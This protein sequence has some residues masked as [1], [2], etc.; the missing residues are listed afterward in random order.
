MNSIKIICSLIFLIFFA[1]SCTQQSKSA[2]LTT[3]I[4]C[5]HCNEC[6]SCK[7]RVENALKATDGVKSAEMKVEEKIIAVDYDASKIDEQQ[8]KQVIAKTGYDAGDVKADP[9]AYDQLDDCCK[10]K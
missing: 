7:E 4:Y 8:I 2:S 6:E 10:K 9:A 5:D 1:N 3:Q